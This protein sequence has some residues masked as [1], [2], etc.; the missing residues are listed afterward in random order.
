MVTDGTYTAVLDR[1]EGEDAVLILEGDDQPAGQ[2]VVAS[3]T[4]P[5][6][7][8]HQD[9]LFTVTVRDEALVDATYHPERTERRRES[10]QSRFDR[11]A[12]RS[13]REE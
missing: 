4:L 6:D 7:G 10:A 5:D 9:A 3:E 13:D 8:H 1:F 11:L 2:L 12:R